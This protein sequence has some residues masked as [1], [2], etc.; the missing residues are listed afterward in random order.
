VGWFWPIVQEGGPW[1]AF[2]LL[3]G[4]VIWMRLTDR[5]MTDKGFDRAVAGYVE[6]NKNLTTELAFWRGAAQDKDKTIKTLADQN[7]QLMSQGKVAA[8]FWEQIGKEAPR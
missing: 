1:A 4:L 2:L 7:A 5:W 3:L 8:H 6:S